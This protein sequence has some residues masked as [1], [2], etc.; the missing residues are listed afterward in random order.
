MS[1]TSVSFSLLSGDGF[2]YTSMGFSLVLTTPSY[3]LLFMVYPCLWLCPAIHFVF[4]ICFSFVFPSSL[5]IF[6]VVQLDLVYGAT[7][8]CRL[9]YD[10]SITV[11]ACVCLRDGVLTWWPSRVLFT[12]VVGASMQMKGLNVW[13]PDFYDPECKFQFCC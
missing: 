3:R 5:F 6:V 10:L 1:F 8:V 13:S 9:R 11:C 2:K 12:Y 4:V 7:Q